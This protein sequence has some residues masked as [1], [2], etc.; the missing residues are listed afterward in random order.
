MNMR[1]YSNKKLTLR[2]SCDVIES[3]GFNV[4][5]YV[6]FEYHTECKIED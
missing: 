6:D 2:N 4:S 1:H 5:I 3:V